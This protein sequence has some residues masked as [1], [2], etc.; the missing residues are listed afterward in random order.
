[1]KPS[2]MPLAM[3]KILAGICA[4]EARPSPWIEGMKATF[5]RRRRVQGAAWDSEDEPIREREG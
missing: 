3:A 2:A 1:M 4:K 5:P